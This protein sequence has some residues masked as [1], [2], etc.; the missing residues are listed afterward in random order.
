MCTPILTIV[1][2]LVC[3]AQSSAVAQQLNQVLTWLP[4]DTE[5]VLG[6]NGPFPWEDPR[7]LLSAAP[8]NERVAAELDMQFRMLP[9]ML[10]IFKNGGLSE[11]VKGKTV[12]L[13]IEGSRRFRP[14]QSLGDMRYEGCLIVI[15]GPEVSLDGAAF[16]QVA[17][18][19]AVRF[20]EAAGTKVAV[21][22][23]KSQ[24]DT[25]TTFVGFPRTN[26]AVVATNLGYL[27]TL[28]DR[29]KSPQP[30]RAL[31]QDL[32]EWKH[33]DT[34]APVWGIRH[35]RKQGAELDPTSPL[36]GKNAA[37][38]PDKDAVGVTFSFGRAADPTAIVDY[39]SANPDARRI[40]SAYLVE[41]GAATAV[42]RELQMRLRQPAAGVLKAS[43]SLPP[44]KPLGDYCSE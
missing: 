42:P 26:M 2:I 7:A 44:A 25:W 43:I 36:Q 8:P 16:M 29:M 1:A 21:F 23:E 28:L 41:E 18:N 24:Q 39:L 31:P 6:A 4:D 32:P 20:E 30:T 33:V 11:F 9:F 12:S 3:A 13:A 10:L 38:V 34:A 27:T 35:Y 5:T 37:N 19:S 17:A 14:P 22:E 40:L 15:F